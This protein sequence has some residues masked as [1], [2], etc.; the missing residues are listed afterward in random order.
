MAILS[1]LTLLSLSQAVTSDLL[2]SEAVHLVSYSGDH[3]A[4]VLVP[5][6]RQSRSA[7]LDVHV[8]SPL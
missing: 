5:N 6:W 7:A 3:P 1:A 2:R 8:I 4:D